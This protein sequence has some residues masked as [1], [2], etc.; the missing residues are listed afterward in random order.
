[1]PDWF[2]LT[3]QLEGNQV[4]DQPIAL[5]RRSNFI[6]WIAVAIAV[7]VA[8]QI[9]KWAIIEWVSLYD[10]V[11][12]NSFMN[13]THQRNSGAAF[14]FLAGAGGWQRWFFVVL[15]T[16]VS[17]VIAGWLWRIRRDGPVMLA[18]GLALVLGG[19]IGNLIDRAR[20]GYVTDFIQVWFGGWAFPS[21]NVAD[22]AI[23]VGAAFLI[24]DALF[25]SGRAKKAE[26]EKKAL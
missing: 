4:T 9:T 24:I 19:A 22:S 10:R 13:L 2:C 18:A 25:L 14:S 20:L 6:A 16:V 17:G 23:T 12:I 3:L 8:D 7:I 21:F 5:A 26:P 1:M 11:P 15:A